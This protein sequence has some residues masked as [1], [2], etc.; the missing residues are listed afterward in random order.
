[1]KKIFLPSLFLLFFLSLTLTQ[2]ITTDTWWNLSDGRA[3][4]SEGRLPA[5]DPY[6]YVTEGKQW[7]NGSW[8][9]GVLLYPVYL[10]GG[11]KALVLFQVLV[12]ALIFFLLQGIR[13]QKFSSITFVSL[14]LCLL[15]AES[16]F[17]VRAELF[18]LLSTA[19]FLRLLFEYQRGLNIFKAFVG[20]IL[21]MIFWV[22]T[23][24]SF[25]L[26]ILLIGVFS[27]GEFFSSVSLK[28]KIGLAGIF[29][30]VLVA[31]GITPY[32]YAVWKIPIFFQ[33][34]GKFV[35]ENL[36]EWVSLSV[37][38]F[39]KIS[40]VTGLAIVLS[41]L[42]AISGIALNIKR[43]SLSW[44]L[45]WILS[46]IM[47]VSS[48]R[49][50]GFFAMATLPILLLY[51]KD[52]DHRIVQKGLIVAA[53]ICMIFVSFDRLTD[54][55]VLE[56]AGYQALGLGFY[57]RTMLKEAVSFAKSNDLPGNIF[58]SYDLG[59]YLM[60][61]WPERKVFIDTRMWFRGAEDFQNYIDLMR[62]PEK[63]WDA[64]VEKYGIETVILKHLSRETD[65][66]IPYLFK[67][68]EWA[69]IFCDARGI[70]FLKRTPTNETLIGKF[71]PAVDIEGLF[72]KTERA[73]QPHWFWRR[74]PF[75]RPREIPFELYWVAYLYFRLEMYDRAE[76]AFLRVLEYTP[77]L[78]D[79]YF[80][81]GKIAARRK[82]F[83]SAV[84]MF[85]KTLALNPDFLPAEKEL[86]M[87]KMLAGFHVIQA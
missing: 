43:I 52:I 2:I 13:T 74:F 53:C 4:F 64:L 34:H 38:W 86:K 80:F 18:G 6:S 87:S 27:V 84:E 37:D 66:L 35:R 25:P 21:T 79:G 24:A 33:E 19:I 41:T 75:F 39:R 44:V 73:Y 14:V 76:K 17:Q 81:L 47:F 15:A 29:L 56:R 26:G 82:D 57:E 20:F 31:T 85:E 30:A 63:Y 60:F 1:M 32:G 69:A 12:V 48:V 71:S 72:E 16:R 67:H 46:F 78:H 51:G 54:R 9:S 50:V 36:S 23:H 68:S 45:I 70:I 58:N 28:R 5:T 22:N 10:L 42:G 11:S 55:G 7:V 77:D 65:V 59:S 40:P 62:E 61:H 8:L 49:H 83:K 3:F